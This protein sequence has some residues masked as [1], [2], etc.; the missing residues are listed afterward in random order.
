M[1]QMPQA[2]KC[3]KWLTYEPKNASSAAEGGRSFVAF[4]GLWHLK[5][6]GRLCAGLS[7]ILG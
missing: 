3:H 2:E 5:Q 4:F 6:K 1:P 7:K